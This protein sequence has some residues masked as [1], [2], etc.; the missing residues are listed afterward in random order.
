MKSEFTLSAISVAVVLVLWQIASTWLVDDTFLPSPL[1]VLSA[2]WT[3]LLNGTLITSVLVSMMR[4][5]AGWIIGSAVAIPVGLVVGSSRVMRAVVDPF[6]HF[7]RFVPAIAL[8]TLF[9]VWFGVG[10]VSKILLIAYAT[11]F[12]VTVNTASGVAAI[13]ADKLNA[14]RCLGASANQVFLRVVIPAALPAIYVGMRLALASSFLVI[15]AAEMLAA[16]SGLGYIIWTSRLYFQ[17]DWM[18][19]AIVVLGLLGFATD[20]AWRHIGRTLLSRYLR[21]MT[22]Y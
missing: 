7:F 2:S 22:T 14:A 8:V 10:E 15:V 16:D 20:R 17:V 5:L 18:F 13:S 6:V 4:I 19:A 12:I 21:G 9:I 3:L 11:A 1:A